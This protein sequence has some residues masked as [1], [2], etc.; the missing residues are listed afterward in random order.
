VRA[1][2]GCLLVTLVCGPALS[3]AA[4]TP[5]PAG[6]SL[7][8]ADRWLVDAQGRVAILHGVNVV[9]TAPAT[10]ADFDDADAAFLARNGFSLVRLG[11]QLSALEPTPGHFDEQYLATLKRTADLLARHGI[12][13]LIDMHQD[14]WGPSIG[15]RGF[16]GWM[17][18][19]DGL[20]APPTGQV[21][22]L[23]YWT[24]PAINRAWKNFWANRPVADGRGVQDVLAGQWRRVARRFRNQPLV[25]GYDMLNEPYPGED[26]PYP[27]GTCWNPLVRNGCP[28]FDA[29]LASF[30]ARVAGAIHAM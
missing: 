10:T 1:A 25:L 27:A 8:H 18:L 4:H 30:N 23:G 19:D 2:L 22:P 5:R 9:P 13:T 28:D 14:E 6:A 17:T 16:P 11:W 7:D 29:K 12:Y 3:A 20:P 21:H 26:Y 24:S 15:I